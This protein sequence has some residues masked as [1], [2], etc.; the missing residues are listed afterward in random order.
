MKKIILLFAAVLFVMAGNA[1]KEETMDSVQY[2][3]PIDF[4]LAEATTDS[5]RYEVLY[6]THVAA[7]AEGKNVSYEG[8][9]SLTIEVKAGFKSIPLTPINDFHGMTLTVRNN[10]QKYFLFEMIQPATPIEIDKSLV[11]EGDFRDVDSLSEGD[12]LLILEDETPWVANRAGYAYGATRK[13]ILFIHDGKAKN[14]P[15]ASYATDTTH[16]KASYCPATPDMKVISNLKIVR[17]SSSTYKTKCIYVEGYNNL[18]IS[19]VQLYTPQNSTMYADEAFT[20]INCTNVTMEDVTIEGTYSQEKKYGYGIMMNNIWNATFQRLVGHAQ[21]GIFG[22]NNMNNIT[23][24][25]CD[26]NRF[27][28]HCYGKD[29]FIYNCKFTKLYNQFSSVFG[30][31]LFDGCRF[32]NF[33]PVLIETSYNAYTPFDLTFKDCVMEAGVSRNFLISIGKLNNQA[34]SRP[35][36]ASKCWPNVHI[37]NLIVNVPDKVSEIILFKPTGEITYSKSVDYVSKVKVEGLT[38]NYSGS[39]HAANF[40]ISSA[41][42]TSAKTIQYDIRNMDLLP[43]SDAQIKQATKKYVYPASLTINLCRSKEDVI[44]ILNSR[45]NFNVLTN[46]QYSIRFTGCT[47]G[48]VRYAMPENNSKRLYKQCKIYLNNADDNRY[49]I[50]NHADYEKCTFIPC[51]NKMFV[52]FYGTKNDVSIK[53]C[54]ST[55]STALFYRGSS[56]NTELKNFQVKGERKIR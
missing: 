54:K 17:D 30:E 51:S 19:N 20:L 4:G 29:V 43:G 12:W 56:N 9:D 37:K 22:T 25:D 36:I 42:V 27:D 47:V 45:L 33:V 41:P 26:I 23:L 16:L 28:V 14:A 32:V 10:A 53:S 34:V 40:V 49:Y 39:G 46:G 1:Q 31:V 48:M 11:D 44:K 6:Q 2:L 50:D 7:L 3:S 18:K 8:I 55:R 13:D 5:A 21:W 35:E 24:R 38:F 15:I 52:D